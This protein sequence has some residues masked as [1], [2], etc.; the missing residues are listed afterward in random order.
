MRGEILVFIVTEKD[1]MLGSSK[2]HGD[3]MHAMPVLIV[4]LCLMAIAYRY[5]SAFLAAK[6][7]ALDDARTTPAV[8]FHDGQ[9]YHPTNKWVLFGHHF[10]AISGAGP[11]IGPVLAAQF[12]YLPGLMWIVI[13]VCLGGAVQ[14]FL[15]LAASLRRG[16]KSLAQIAFSD[17]GKVAGT[18]ATVAILFIVIIALAGLG[19][20]VVKALGGEEIRYPAGSRF[21]IAS[22]QMP[23]KYKFA[24]Q[25]KKF[26]KG[27]EFCVYAIPAGWQMEYAARQSP[28]TFNEGF[29]LLTTEPRLNE[30]IVGG[31]PFDPDAKNSLPIPPD[32]FRP[33]PGSPWGTF[34]IACTIPI[35]LFVGLYMYKLRPGK[36]VEASLIGAA[37]TLAAVWY[38]AKVADA[39]WGHFFNLSAAKVTWSMAIY[40]FIAAV[41]PVWVLLAPRDY[42]S[43]FLKIGT[44]ALLVVGTLVANPM[45]EAPAINHVFL[46]GGPTVV[47][48]IF[49]FLFTTIMCGAI[50]GFHALV[51]SGTTPKM[52]GKES[53][54]RMIGYG[55]MLIE[56]LVAVVAMIAAAAL[57]T[58]DYYAMNTELSKVPQFHE[59]ILQVGGGGGAE[60]IGEYEQLTKEPSL[61]GRTGGAVTLAVGM[62]HIFDEAARKMWHGGEAAM[63]SL[64][65]YWYH[66]AIMFEALFILTTIDA[67]TRIGRFL[68]QEA[69]GKT[70]HPQFAKAGWWPGAI[71][72]TLLVVAGW[73]YFIDAN[74]F[75][76]IWKMFGVANQMLAAIALSIVSAYLVNEGRQRYLWVTL[77]PLAVVM[78]TTS[79]AAVENIL[80]YWNTIKAQ[81]A[82]PTPDWKLVSNSFI[83]GALTLAMLISAYIVIVAAL[84]RCYSNSPFSGSP[85]G[86]RSLITE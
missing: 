13:G 47:G 65:K 35:A 50:S 10:A 85:E 29:K 25:E 56:G 2:V 42:L 31:D 68:L 82:L 15:V 9:N 37:L 33:T 43:S 30:K 84:K 57:P 48:K 55:A 12:G 23:D 77:I 72:S 17:V 79:T 24:A 59:K 51:S 28:M 53:D 27:K 6:V 16:G 60:H 74:N 36:V 39:S 45:L 78:T 70:I 63:N 66:F 81:K 52:V 21:L 3:S 49:P 11:L 19:K 80:T 73:A 34:T 86:T 44:I 7:A 54:A 5:Y 22:D 40:G 83:S 62:A 64:W 18:A 14:D 8:R 46:G 32:A 58:N 69:M 61:R 71:L 41:L 20:V 1:M 26:I 67:G 4:I 38:G 75:D 76:A